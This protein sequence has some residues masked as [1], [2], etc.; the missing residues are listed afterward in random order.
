MTGVGATGGARGP[1]VSTR[2]ATATA[3]GH[4]AA[5]LCGR[6]GAAH[7]SGRRARRQAGPACASGP[8]AERRPN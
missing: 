3:Y 6:S 1:P 4:A 8:E 2:G 7:G 5:E